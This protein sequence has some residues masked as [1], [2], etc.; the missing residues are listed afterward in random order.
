MAK[1]IL[2][3]GLIIAVCWRSGFG[4]RPETPPKIK[5]VASVFPLL[6]FARGV[7]GENGD[8][9]LLLPPGA[10]VH[11]W[12]PR[13]SDIIRLSSADLFIYIGA[14]LEPWIADVLRSVSS[15]RLHVFAATDALTLEKHEHGGRWEVDPHIW[16]DFQKDLIIVDIIARTLGQLDPANAEAYSSRAARYGEKLKKMDERFRTG[17]SRCAHR[18]LLLGGHAAFGYLAEKYGLEQISVFGMNPDAEPSPSQIVAAIEAARKSNLKAVFMEANT[19]S[20]MSRILARELPAELLVLHPG[21]NL[22]RKEWSSGLTFLDIMEANLKNL[23]KG[24]G[25]E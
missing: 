22:S 20:K 23:R 10:G 4:S 18:T 3:L 9:S 8:V 12:Q 15:S 1:N 16:L 17:L 2:T 5:I 24:L 19:S 11:T 6:E 13:A 25:C 14:G 7:A 21:A